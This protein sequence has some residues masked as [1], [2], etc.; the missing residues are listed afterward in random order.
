[1]DLLVLVAFSSWLAPALGKHCFGFGF[2]FLGLYVCFVFLIDLNE[3]PHVLLLSPFGVP[4]RFKLLGVNTSVVHDD[5]N[6]IMP[7]E[8]NELGHR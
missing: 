1:M 2:F 7:Y 3:A 5:D 6:I 8:L 4:L